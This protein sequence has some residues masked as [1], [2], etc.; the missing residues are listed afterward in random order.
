MV[1]NM[2]KSTYVLWDSAVPGELCDLALKNLDWEAARKGTVGGDD[3]TNLEKRRTD[4]IWENVMQPLGCIARMYIG[5]SNKG[6]EWNFDATG[7]ESTQLTRYRSEEEGFYDWHMDT[8]PPENGLQRK[9]T[10]VI[11]LNNSSE[12]EGG[13]LEIEGANPQPLLTNKGSIVV[14]PAFLPHR[15]TPVTSG[16]RYTAVTWAS[17]PAFK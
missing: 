5:M 8:I 13:V 12:F 4:I 3:N 7:Q 11:L 16:V 1:N 10:C 2:F 17:G 14:F 9:L 15:V 6:G